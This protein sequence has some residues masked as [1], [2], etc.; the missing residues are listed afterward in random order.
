MDS[1]N[2]LMQILYAQIGTF[3]FQRNL[4]NFINAQDDTIV[5]FSKD[6]A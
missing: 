3:K 6:E 1:V 2:E 5:T 4:S